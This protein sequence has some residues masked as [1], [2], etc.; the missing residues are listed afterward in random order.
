MLAHSRNRR[1]PAVQQPSRVRTGLFESDGQVRV[2]AARVDVQVDSL[3]TDWKAFI[4]KKW[5]PD[6]MAATITADK[7]DAFRADKTF[8]AAWVKWRLGWETFYSDIKD[9]WY[10]LRS[11]DKYRE[12]EQYDLELQAWRKKFEERKVKVSMPS[13]SKPGLLGPTNPDVP[14]PDGEIPWTGILIVG[15][16]VA[17]AS[18]LKSLT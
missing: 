16:L 1:A 5:G 13:P 17:G 10:Y 12:V 4:V 11:A 8:N 6:G 2:Y 14:K 7:L 3:N 18:I 9:S 15:G